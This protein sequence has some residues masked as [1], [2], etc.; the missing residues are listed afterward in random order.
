MK[1]WFAIGAIF[2]SVY[3]AFVIVAIPANFIVSYVKLPNNI[4]LNGIK[5]TIWQM[6]VDEVVHP[7]ITLDNVEVSLSIGS[8]FSLDPRVD[9]EFGDDFSVGPSGRLSVAGLLADM[10]ISDA[11]MAISADAI[12]QQLTLPLPLVASGDINIFIKTFIVGQPICQNIQGNITWKK[13]SLS[14]FN[15]TVQLGNLAANLSCKEGALAI[16]IDEK[17]DLGLSFVT[18]VRPKKV[19]GNGH[20]QPAKNFPEN[21][22]AVLPFLGKPNKQGRYRLFF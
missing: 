3:L 6:T 11:S 10:T 21:L 15:E 4:A 8:F 13:P 20:L 19:S 7:K 5:G 22:K 14:A 1:K 12:A 9:L 18:Y 16:T 2:I 17:N